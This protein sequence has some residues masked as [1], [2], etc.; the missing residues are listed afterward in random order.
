MLERVFV[1][2][3][4]VLQNIAPTSSVG[5]PFEGAKEWYVLDTHNL[6]LLLEVIN[7]LSLVLESKKKVKK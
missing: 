1:K 7:A 4:A 5:E 6:S 2:K 3:Y